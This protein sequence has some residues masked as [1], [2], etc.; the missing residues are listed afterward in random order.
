MLTS[1]EILKKKRLEK[2]LSFEDIEKGTKIRKKFLEALEKGELEKLPGETYVQGFVKN[3]ADFLSLPTANVLAILRREYFERNK[4]GIIPE[5]LT[6]PLV[7][8]RLFT[9]KIAIPLAFIIGLIIL[10]I[11]LYSQFLHF[12]SKPDLT[13]KTPKD[14]QVVTVNKILIVGT[15]DRETKVFINNQEINTKED[16]TFQIEVNL[17]E[18][19]NIFTIIAVNQFSKETKITRKVIKKV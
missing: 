10:I 9:R 15:T 6:N 11:Y 5:G 3:Y 16:G 17:Q 2:N 19:E 14:N 1:G 18:E 12:Q 13:I 7:N 8:S 4:K